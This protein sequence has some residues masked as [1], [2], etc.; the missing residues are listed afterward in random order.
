MTWRERLAKW[1]S[2]PR[3][4]SRKDADFT[5][6]QS[7]R[8]RYGVCGPEVM[9][10][11]GPTVGYSAAAATREFIG[12]PRLAASDA[13]ARPDLMD[14]IGESQRLYRDNT[15]Y[16]A[17]VGRIV[18]F[19]VAE[20]PNPQVR[21][22]SDADN[23][24]VEAAFKTWWEGTPEIR[25][26]DDGADLVRQIIRH[27]IVDGRMAVIPIERLGQLQ[28]ITGERLF[29]YRQVGDNGRYIEGGV[30]TDTMNR[31]TG[32]WIGTWDDTKTYLREAEK[33]IPASKVWYW[34][35]RLRNDETTGHPALQAVFPMLHRLN[36]VCDSEVYAWQLLS[37]MVGMV[38]MPNAAGYA[39]TVSTDTSMD[40]QISEFLR[41]SVDWGYGNFFFAEPGSD[42]KSVDRNIPGQNFE[43]SL[44]AF[45][46]LI[47]MEIGLSLEFLLLIWSDTNYS[48][49]RMSSKQVERNLRPW[50]QG[51]RRILNQIFQ[52]WY[53]RGQVFDGLPA[54]PAY[55]DW[56]FSSYP[57]ID[58]QKESEAE[59]SEIAGGF[60][61][62][63]RALR[64]RGVDRDEHNAERAAELE[65]A[66]VLVEAHNAAHPDAPVTIAQFLEVGE[67]TV[68][69]SGN[70]GS[71]SADT[72]QTTDTDGNSVA[73]LA[74]NG[75]QITAA[76]DVISKVRSGVISSTAAVELLAAVGLSREAAE[77]SVAST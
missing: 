17:I 32:Y 51:L 30:Q 9:A 72:I 8:I 45:L 5:P 25:G 57:F 59:R 67:S 28:F 27:R 10:F 66:A 38:T 7:K 74:L 36:D 55:C 68:D 48:S 31:P 58:P 14:L 64:E 53:E 15:I 50:V 77:Q 73:M 40:S 1:I 75:A 11:T 44:K 20:G 12:Q 13:H 43:S 56:H 16:R 19:I 41:R 54:G 2:P 22:L 65:A 52:W 61:T 37:R 49:G 63:T 46:R 21:G 39:Q 76:V 42:M 60:K 33:A 26:M 6:R 70:S 23:A 18:D 35:F 24:T 62:Q 69:G 29:T 34:P 3:P 4:R 71:G 47:G